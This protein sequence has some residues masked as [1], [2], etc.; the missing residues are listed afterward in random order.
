MFSHNFLSI[1][2]QVLLRKRFSLIHSVKESSSYFGDKFDMSREKRTSDLS[3]VKILFWRKLKV[4]VVLSKTFLNHFTVPENSCCTFISIIR[5]GFVHD[6]DIFV[7]VVYFVTI[8]LVRVTLVSH[9][10]SFDLE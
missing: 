2:S 3:M 6:C 4:P 7:F 9:V 1:N 10:M 8:E 5:K